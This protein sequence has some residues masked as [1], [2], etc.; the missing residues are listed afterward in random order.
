MRRSVVLPWHNS[1]NR[2]NDGGR[3]KQS[4]NE[5]GGQLAPTADLSESLPDQ[6]IIGSS[7]FSESLASP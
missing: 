7:L 4:R 3:E 2:K 6:S 5:K 1:K